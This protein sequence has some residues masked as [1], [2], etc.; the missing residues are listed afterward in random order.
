MPTFIHVWDE[1][2]SVAT[3]ECTNCGERMG[4]WEINQHRCEGEYAKGDKAESEPADP[5]GPGGE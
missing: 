5:E 1:R 2:S 4:L 3:A